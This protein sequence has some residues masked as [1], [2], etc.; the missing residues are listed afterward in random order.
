MLHGIW[1]GLT[2][3]LVF[4]AFF[5]DAAWSAQSERWVPAGL[6]SLASAGLAALLWINA[7]LRRE[8][9]VERVVV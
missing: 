2:L 1:N 9:A 6:V 3:T 5:P 7:R 8:M 4:A